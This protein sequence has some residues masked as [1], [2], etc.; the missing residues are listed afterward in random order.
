MGKLMKFYVNPWKLGGKLTPTQM[1]I[2]CDVLLQIYLQCIFLS[3]IKQPSVQLEIQGPHDW[4]DCLKGEGV[5]LL[6]DLLWTEVT[7]HGPLTARQGPGGQGRQILNENSPPSP[8]YIPHYVSQTRQS[9]DA[10]LN[11]FSSEIFHSDFLQIKNKANSVYSVLLWTI[12]LHKWLKNL[13]TMA[14]SLSSK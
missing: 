6:V 11:E 8:S 10:V 13:I 14:T 1:V 7:C 12:L 3:F 4:P 2:W 9:L 5:G